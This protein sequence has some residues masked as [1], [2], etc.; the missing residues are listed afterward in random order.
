MNKPA[1]SRRP[2]HK[3]WAPG[4][5]TLA[6]AARA[7]G[8]IALDGR[9]AEDALAAFEQ[10]AERS[11]IRAITL[12]TVRWY[13][14]LLPAM[15]ALLERP[16]GLPPEVRVLLVASAH[17]IEYSRNPH[18]ST[19]DAAVDAVRILKH[20]RSAGLVNAVL[21]RFLREKTG[22]LAKV[23]ASI[24]ARTAHPVWFVDEIEV[25]WPE[26][27]AAILDANNTH[28]PM[29]V[30]VDRTKVSVEEYLSELQAA[31]ITAQPLPWA[32]SALKLDQPVAVGGLPGFAE[33]RVS[34]QDGGAQL[35]APL[36]ACEPGMRVLDACAAPG[37]KTG[38]LLELT[39]DLKELV[40]VDVD[41]R[42]LA[43][44]QEN[45]DRLK[46]SATLRVADARNP[47]SFWDRK[48]FDRIL[49]D[50]PCSSTGVIR[51][52]PD[53]KLL[54]RASDIQ[55][56]AA[57]QLEMLRACFSMLAPGGR[58][59]YST[60]SVLPE[61]NEGVLAEFLRSQRRARPVPVP[62]AAAVPGAVT[63]P[64]GIQLLPGTETGTDGFHYAC[65]EKTTDGT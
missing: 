39:P 44:V 47:E 12:G 13:L 30:R 56:L 19:V 42:R 60:C 11:A 25:A 32:D 38:H 50:A 63:R 59:L 49:L 29:I 62:L 61:E 23:D 33:G 36:L 16:E 5:D 10:H 9:S 17:Q 3:K 45:L 53:I 2:A 6:S 26:H 14:R 24:A 54:R 55:A 18:H 51:R 22:L 20:D 35:A 57:T 58:L 31:Q 28:P 4:T 15:Q 27:F 37:G 52:H 8:R 40:A 46:R 64:I 34:V 21:R 48:P 65:V 43:R 1:S 41:G 7:V